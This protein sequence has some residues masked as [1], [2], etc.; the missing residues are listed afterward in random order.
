MKKYII[1]AAAA[2]ALAACNNEVEENLDDT[3]VAAQISAGVSTR[4]YNDKWEADIIGVMVTGG[5]NTMASLYKNVPYETSADG[6]KEADFKPITEPIYFRGIEVA[7]FAAYGPYNP[8]NFMNEGPDDVSYDTDNQG[9]REDQRLIDYIYAS[10]ATGSLDNPKVDFTFK[11]VMARLVIKVQASDESNIDFQDILDGEYYL[12]GLIHSGTFHVTTGEATADNSA[13]ATSD[14][15]LKSCS[16][17]VKGT[18][19]ITFTAILF[20]QVAQD[21]KFKANIDGKDYSTTFTPTLE[22][23]HSYAITITVKKAELKMTGSTID[24]WTD[25]S[26]SEYDAM[27]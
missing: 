12:D 18:K 2:L 7:Y 1:F 23:G 25:G 9:G 27:M 20:P 11:H 6:T 19:D 17:E 26:T 16:V 22:A 13:Q 5:N 3:Q 8:S 10:G 4:A 21:L 24:K 15:D 14:W